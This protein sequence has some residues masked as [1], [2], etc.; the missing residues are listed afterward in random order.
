MAVRYSGDLVVASI[1]AKRWRLMMRFGLIGSKGDEFWVEPGDVTDF[2]SVPWWTQAILP[3]TGTWTKAAVFHDK[4]CDLQNEYYELKLMWKDLVA[5]GEPELE[6]PAPPIFNSVD[7]D[8][9]FRTNARQDGTDPIRSELLWF[10]VRCG[11]LK[12]AARRE[13]WMSTFPRWFAD[14]IGIVASL[15]VFT[16]FVLWV[17]HGFPAVW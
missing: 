13:G 17:A 1:D 10:G 9:L 16:F 11:A 6:P 2:A 15:Y 3:R 14:L 8:A 7:T 12:N 5:A 4:M